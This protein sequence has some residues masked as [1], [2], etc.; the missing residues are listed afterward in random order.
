[1]RPANANVWFSWHAENK[2]NTNKK[3][4]EQP[5]QQQRK[6]TK[7]RKKKWDENN[8]KKEKKIGT[9]SQT[10]ESN[11]VGLGLCVSY[12]SYLNFVARR[13]ETEEKK[14][15]RRFNG[16]NRRR[17]RYRANE[18]AACGVAFLSMLVCFSGASAG[19]R[20]LQMKEKAA[21]WNICSDRSDT[22]TRQAQSCLEEKK[23]IPV[24]WNVY[25]ITVWVNGTR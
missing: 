24:L 2:V 5:D 3:T 1:M 17:K 4:W 6:K 23:C 14:W 9:L 15:R 21:M 12:F 8:E 7:I 19:P 22:G 16:K 10:I 13:M 25:Y 18:S 20:C 11:C